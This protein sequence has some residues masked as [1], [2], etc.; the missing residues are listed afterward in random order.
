VIESSPHELA[1]PT[2]NVKLY[3]RGNLA[4]DLEDMPVVQ[5]DDSVLT[6]QTSSEIDGRGDYVITAGLY[7]E[8]SRAKEGF[9]QMSAN[10]G[11]SPLPGLHF[12][13]CKV[14]SWN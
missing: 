3:Y 7:W 10:G 14:L 1:I 5:S 2:Y 8:G 11:E 9:F 4:H 6:V 13:N 12:D